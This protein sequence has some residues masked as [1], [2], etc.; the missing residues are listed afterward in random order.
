MDDTDKDRVTPMEWNI[1]YAPAYNR[2]DEKHGIDLGGSGWATV[3]H[4]SSAK[5]ESR[6]AHMIVNSVNA[7]HKH[8]LE[9]SDLDAV[10]EV[11]GLAREANDAG[12]DEW[13]DKLYEL[14]EALARLDE[15]GKEC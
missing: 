5:E 15:G 2:P 13:R 12:H 6:I 14:S 4:Y 9:P 1:G 10:M 7:L 8:G 11:V 3:E